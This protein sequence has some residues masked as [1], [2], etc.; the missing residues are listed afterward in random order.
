[1]GVVKLNV[2]GTIY[3]TR[4]RTLMQAEGSLLAEKFCDE[5]Y[6]PD[7]EGTYFI[8][9]HA[10]SFGYM[11]QF[12]R[13]GNLKMPARKEDVYMLKQEAEFFEIPALVALCRNTLK[14]RS[15][16]NARVTSRKYF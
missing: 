15:R 14:K 16:A 6:R 5:Y 2:C 8:D 7:Y 11:L 3:M 10:E 13:R 4:R 9:A 12:L 1:M